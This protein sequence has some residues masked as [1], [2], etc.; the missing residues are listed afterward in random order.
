MRRS[1]ARRSPTAFGRKVVFV[2]DN[3]AGKTTLL[4][5]F[6]RSIFPE[7]Y[8]PSAYE[9]SEVQVHVDEHTS[10]QLNL[11]DIAY[12][13]DFPRLRPLAYPLTD[14]F[15]LCFSVGDPR[16]LARV[17]SEWFPEIRHHCPHS[18]I[19]LVGCRKDL[20]DDPE[21]LADLARNGRHPVTYE[22]G[23]R[24]AQLMGAAQYVECS[25][26]QNDGVNDVFKAAALQCGSPCKMPAASRRC[27]LL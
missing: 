12:N 5:V 17:E 16:T 8:V 11:W 4:I 20:R 2:G 7:V 18:P 3:T 6:A 22:E 14:V 13:D 24:M 10:V 25:A 19:L 15:V 27:R 23:F 1:Q 26:I 9:Y 21:T